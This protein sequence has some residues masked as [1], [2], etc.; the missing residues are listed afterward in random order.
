MQLV[1]LAKHWGAS[2]ASFSQKTQIDTQLAY[3]I[4]CLTL[5]TILFGVKTQTLYFACSPMTNYRLI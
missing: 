3:I 1:L 4:V 5:F 2:Y